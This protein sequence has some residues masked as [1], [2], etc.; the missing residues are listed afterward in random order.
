MN[1]GPTTYPAPL[2]ASPAR[3]AAS[4]LRFDPVRSRVFV[5]QQLTNDQM[6][7]ADAAA[8]PAE[9]LPNSLRLLP[10]TR[11]GGPRGP[12]PGDVIYWIACLGGACLLIL[13]A[14]T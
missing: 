11:G 12:H 9:A 14:T 8:H 10:D 5:P 13:C 4:G 1:A 3:F 2:A 7:Q 6:L